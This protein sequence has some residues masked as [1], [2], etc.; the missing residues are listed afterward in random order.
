MPQLDWMILANYAEAPP[1]GGLVYIHGGAW[2]TLT[3]AAPMEGPEGMVAALTGSL[4]LRILFHSTE[5]GRE[6]VAEILLMDADGGE[7][8]KV[9]VT[10]RIERTHGLPASWLQGSNLVIPLAGIGLPKFG[11]YTFS[12]SINGNHMSDRPFRVLKGY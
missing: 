2:D 10:F 5:S 12:L 9:D 11:E 7:V 4:A 1:Q 6:H 3:V 8:A